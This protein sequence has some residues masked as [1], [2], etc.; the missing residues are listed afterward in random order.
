MSK[1]QVPMPN[2]SKANTHHNRDECICLLQPTDIP[3]AA[4]QP[5]L[6]TGAHARRQVHAA[7][8]NHGRRR[9]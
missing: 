5:W 1:T 6:T 2:G 9:P 8:G 4:R 3:G 7:L